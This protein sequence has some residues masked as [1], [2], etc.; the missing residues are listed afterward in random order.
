MS[1][2]LPTRRLLLAFFCALIGSSQLPDSAL[3]QK[4]KKLPYC[5]TQRDFGAWRA[6]VTDAVFRLSPLRPELE[7]IGSLKDYHWSSFFDW[8]RTDDTRFRRSID[9]GFYMDHVRRNEAFEVT[10][11]NVS[12]DKRTLTHYSNMEQL[13]DGSTPINIPLDE[14]LLGGSSLMSSTGRVTVLVRKGKADVLS[15]AFETEGFNAAL[16]F[17]KVEHA[18]Q[19]S[20]W[21]RKSCSSQSCGRNIDSCGEDV[22]GPPSE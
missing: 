9:I 11:S 15:L 17:G 22:F 10:A 1:I 7:I 16:E 4:K 14:L 21:R 6:D 18:R 20:A 3:G 19:E 12:G 2:A 8:Q 13:D 5:Q